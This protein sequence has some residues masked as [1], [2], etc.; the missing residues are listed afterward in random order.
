VRLSP[1]PENPSALLAATMH[2]T[3]HLAS[4][5]DIA[6]KVEFTKTQA[7]N[8]CSRKPGCCA[9][10]N[11][12]THRDSFACLLL[13][14]RHTEGQPLEKGRKRAYSFKQATHR[15]ARHLDVILS[16]LRALC[17]LMHHRYT[18]TTLS[19][20]EALIH[21]SCCPSSA[22]QV[23]TKRATFCSFTFLQ[24]ESARADVCSVLLAGNMPSHLDKE[25]VL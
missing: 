22:L 15:T 4:D 2:A 17:N 13:Y 16:P 24:K 8:V 23:A 14:E 7:A 12:G 18:A 1:R 11:G 5:D 21:V 6:H 19:Q 25:H 20:T 10:C 9:G 3:K